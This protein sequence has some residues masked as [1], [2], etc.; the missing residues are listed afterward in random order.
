MIQSEFIST[1]DWTKN[2]TFKILNKERL[3]D[4]KG[5]FY[6][7]FPFYYDHQLNMFVGSKSKN[8]KSYDLFLDPALIPN[9]KV[10]QQFCRD[11]S[12]VQMGNRVWIIGGTFP[13]ST[14]TGNYNLD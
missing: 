11:A 5:E 13:C 8:G 3:E 4:I 10:P 2:G 7:Y 14:N 9:S 12:M 6:G 1:L